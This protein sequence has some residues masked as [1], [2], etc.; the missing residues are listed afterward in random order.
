MHDIEEHDVQFPPPSEDIEN[1]IKSQSS[2]LYLNND[3]S[4]GTTIA[5][6]PEGSDGTRSDN[7]FFADQD[8]SIKPTFSTISHDPHD[9]SDNHDEDGSDIENSIPARVISS[10]SSPHEVEDVQDVLHDNYEQSQEAWESYKMDYKG[11]DSFDNIKRKLENTFTVY[12]SNTQD[13]FKNYPTPVIHAP[14]WKH[15]MDQANPVAVS[16]AFS[17]TARFNSITDIMSQSKRSTSVSYSAIFPPAAA[18][19]Y[20]KLFDRNN[21]SSVRMK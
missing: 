21:P 15:T 19:T 1:T 17:S 2:Y 8:T 9:Y 11:V 14:K 18:S 6:D 5:E 10:P 7:E 13:N 12:T 3:S 16:T 20:S 4:F